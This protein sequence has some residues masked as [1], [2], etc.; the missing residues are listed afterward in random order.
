MYRLSCPHGRELEL[1]WSKSRFPEGGAALLPCYWT[2]DPGAQQTTPAPS[3]T[4]SSSSREPGW[5]VRLGVGHRLSSTVVVSPLSTSQLSWCNKTPTLFPGTSIT[6]HT[7]VFS[8]ATIHLPTSNL[9]TL[10]CL[11]YQQ[12]FGTIKTWFFLIQLSTPICENLLVC[13]LPRRGF[14]CSLRGSD[15]WKNT[16][17]LRI[18]GADLPEHL[19]Y[20]HFNSKKPVRFPD[21]FQKSFRPFTMNER[22]YN[23]H[24]KAP[25]S[26]Q[27]LRTP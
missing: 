16:C 27:D 4:T 12:H 13:T 26:L 22:C 11:F 7:E 5:T 17:N 25:S 3:L 21:L 1:V 10:F 15:P 6:N 9:V 23:F 18:T 19:S 2:Q 20:K 24:F 8:F 14:L